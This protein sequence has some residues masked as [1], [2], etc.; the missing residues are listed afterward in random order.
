MQSAG[1]MIPATTEFLRYLRRTADQTG[2][3]LIFD[4]I[5]TARL[6]FNGLQAHHG[7]YP[8]M[9]TL[10]KFFGGGFSFGAFGGRNDIMDTLDPR[11]GQI[12]HSGTFN[13]NTFSMSA[14]VAAC[15]LI[16]EAAIEA[17]N[18]LGDRLRDGIN[19]AG[20]IAGLRLLTAT[21]FGSMIGIHFAGPAPAQLRDAF[22]FHLLS[23]GIYIGRRGFISINMMHKPEH[24]TRVLRAVQ[25]LIEMLL[26]VEMSE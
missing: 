11:N 24:V 22:F 13:N 12:F 19:N 14:G 3:V 23:E 4:E 15:E 26:G 25:I 10:G 9:A 16:S 2:A 17:M 5:V 7:V 21:G 6:C 8:D 20:N 1:G 18:Q